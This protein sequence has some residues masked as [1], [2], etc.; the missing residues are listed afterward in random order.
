M[1]SIFSSAYLCEQSFLKMKYIKSKYRTN[2]SHEH[3]QVTLL[4]EI[5]KFDK[6]YQEI[7]KDKHFQTFHYVTHHNK[8]IFYL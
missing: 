2:I 6:N 4:I 5:T 7:L 8:I 3:L 1:I